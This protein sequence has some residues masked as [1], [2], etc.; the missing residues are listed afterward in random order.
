[1]II[2]TNESNFTNALTTSF[3]TKKYQYVYISIGSKFNQQ[4]VYLNSV[5]G[6]VA[7]RV[8]TNA[9]MQM[10]PMF[11]RT[12]PG[13]THILNIVI[14]TFSTR[15]DM[16]MNKRLINSVTPDNMDCILV[17]MKCTATNLKEIF[18]QIL[19]RVLVQDIN[20][21]CVMI[22]NYVKY[23]NEPN[24]D[25]HETE[26][27]IPKCIQSVL[28]TSNYK[29]CY[30]EWY[31]YKYDLYNCI[32][33]VSFAA[34]DLYFYQTTSHLIHH[35]KIMSRPHISNDIPPCSK[36]DGLLHNSYDISHNYNID[37][38]GIRIACPLKYTITM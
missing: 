28:N 21:L 15:T 20:P 12:K 11:L 32:Y 24:M 30:Y 6:S 36:L 18:I 4:D 31:G 22:C 38:E 8:D 37:F 17:N 7:N 3:Q 5:S 16:D 35:I 10:V 29:N 26:I 13:N 25:E 34:R 19:E 1:M 14:D 23:I 33:N 27:M 2:N 9:I